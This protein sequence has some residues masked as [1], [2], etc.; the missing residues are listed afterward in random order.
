MIDTPDIQSIAFLL[1]DSAR[2]KILWSLIDGTTRPAGELAYAANISAQSASAH[3]AKLVEGGLLRVD[4]QGRH[5]YFRIASSEVANLIESMASLSA[6]ISPRTPRSPQLVRNMPRQ[7]FY[8][9]TCFDHLAGEVAVN[10]LDSMLKAGWLSN[11]GRD[12][13]VSEMGEQKFRDLALDISPE[14]RRAY[15]RVCVDLTERRPHLS[16]VLGSALLRLFVER[17]WIQRSPRSR[18]VSVTPAGDMAIKN[19]FS[20]T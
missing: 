12:F 19:L 20:S 8:A 1:A 13:L 3:L 7:F 9:R 6:A 5:R 14:K 4:T 18:V 10:L 16:G 11:D 17:K 2:A 15:A